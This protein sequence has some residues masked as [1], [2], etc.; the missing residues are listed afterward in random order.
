MEMIAESFATLWAYLSQRDPHE[1]FAGWGILYIPDYV[2]DIFTIKE[3]LLMQLVGDEM[4]V[5]VM[6]DSEDPDFNSDSDSE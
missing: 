2:G 4:G 5:L 1:F 3:G 6:R